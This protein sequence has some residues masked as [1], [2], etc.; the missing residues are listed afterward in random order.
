M[1][2]PPTDRMSQQ[3]AVAELGRAALSGLEVD[4]V[5]HLAVDLIH[6]VLDVKYVKILQQRA[7]DEPLV[8]VAG[9]GWTDDVRIGDLV[10]TYD[11]DAAEGEGE[12]E[13]R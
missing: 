4:N 2:P 11:P 6:E 8:L 9:R 10:F 3:T 12:E 5:F 7:P 13:Y 1:Q